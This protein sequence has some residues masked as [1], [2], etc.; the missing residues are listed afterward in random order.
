MLLG[1]D[2]EW[3]P[4]SGNGPAVRWRY[5]LVN[6]FY[7]PPLTWQR[8]NDLLAVHECSQ[9]WRL[10]QS[11]LN[12][13]LLCMAS[14][15]KK[16]KELRNLSGHAWAVNDDFVRFALLISHMKWTMNKYLFSFL[17]CEVMVHYVRV[18]ALALSRV[19]HN[20]YS[21]IGRFMPKQSTSVFAIHFFGHCGLMLWGNC[22]GT[23]CGCIEAYK[24]LRCA[25]NCPDLSSLLNVFWL[26]IRTLT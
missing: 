2:H 26:M 3:S 13:L 6:I 25:V 11:H 17:F 18:N 14:T 10:I 12:W 23:A 9:V 1:H 20:F 21:N 7:A 4:Q 8:K 16:T 22:E 5:N 19:P 24:R 15:D